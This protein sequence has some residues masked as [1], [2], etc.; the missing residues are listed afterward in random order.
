MGNG[1]KDEPAPPGEGEVQAL[2]KAEAMLESRE[3]E[4]PAAPTEASGR[5]PS[6]SAPQQ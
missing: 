6:P 3:D 4:V 1:A 5:E 2:A